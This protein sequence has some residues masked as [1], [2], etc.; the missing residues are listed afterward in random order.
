MD[1]KSHGAGQAAYQYCCPNGCG[2]KLA[3]NGG[4]HSSGEFL[5][6][7]EV[8]EAVAVR[9]EVPAVQQIEQIEGVKLKTKTPKHRQCHIIFTCPKC[10]QVWKK[11]I[12]LPD[13]GSDQRFTDDP[14][15]PGM[16]GPCLDSFGAAAK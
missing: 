15:M 7:C 13:P 6:Y 14:E 1:D 16:C 2:H 8:C 9:K 5:F 12:P 11:S 3:W 10:S 4:R